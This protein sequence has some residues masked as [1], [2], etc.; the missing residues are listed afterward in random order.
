MRFSF[1][2]ILFSLVLFLLLFISVFLFTSNKGKHITNILIGSFFL[3]IFLNLA[4]GFLLLKQ[5]YFQYPAAGV[6]GSN[7]FLLCGPLI[8]LYTQSI[9]YKDFKLSRN[10]F[11]HFLP[12]GMLFFVSEVGYLALSNQKQIQFLQSIIQQRIPLVFYLIS[13]IIYIHFLAYLILALRSVNRYETAAANHFSEA[14]KVTLDWLKSVIYFFLVLMGV[15]AFNSYLSFRSQKHAFLFVLSVTIFLLLLF[16]VFVLF[17]ALRN[18][19]IFSVWEEKE[20][21]EAVYPTENAAA[22]PGAIIPDKEKSRLVDKLQQ[23]MQA[24]KPYLQP[25]L[26]LDELAGQL[27]VKPKLLSQSINEILQQNFFEFINYYRIEEAKRLLTRPKD[28]KITVLEVMYEVGFNSKSSF[29]TLFKKLTGLTP[30]EFK[31]NHQD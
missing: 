16:I 19:E 5:V 20:V 25:D 7:L 22:N 14:K 12:F 18:P 27:S 6:W 2:D 11:I 26:T 30:S 15:S 10:K 8:F 29:N 17:K 24:H 23:H 31:K 21:E 1:S 3:A 9:I 4:D 28:K 13:G